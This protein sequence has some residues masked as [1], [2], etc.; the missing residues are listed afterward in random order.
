[1]AARRFYDC[2]VSEKL[3]YTAFLLLVGV[4]YLMALGYLYVTH[5][6]NDSKPGL[7][8]TD[9]ADSYYG[10]RSGTRL[11]AAIRGPMAG[12]IQEEDRHV[13]VAWLKDGAPEADYATLIKP[14]LQKTCL[15]CHSTAS[16]RNLPDFTTY[17]GLHEFAKVDTGMS[18]TSLLKLSHIHLFGISLLLFAIG[19]IFIQAEVQ[20][21]FKRFL[22]LSPMVA[23]F[24][25]IMSWFL[26][27]WDPVYA[28]TVVIAGA[29]LG[30]SMAMQML[31]SLYQIWFLKRPNAPR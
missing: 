30:F 2:T 5:A 4:G 31:I 12:Y 29:V 7:S 22:V 28:Y 13:M 6:N 19:F 10:N 3:L 18:L 14:I 9:V 8:V 27:K 1:M 24:V 20:V 25:D 16:G 21:W 26:T 11:E 15:A 17:Q 23:V